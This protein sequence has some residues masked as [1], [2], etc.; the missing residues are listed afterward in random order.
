METISFFMLPFY[1][2]FSGT[3]SISAQPLPQTRNASDIP[4]AE[5]E[6]FTGRFDKRRVLLF[7]FSLEYLGMGEKRGGMQ[8]ADSYGRGICCIIRTWN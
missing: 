1:Y 3:S 5:A 7:A 4:T 2:Y 6:G 8:M